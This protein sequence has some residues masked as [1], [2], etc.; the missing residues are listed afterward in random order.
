[1]FFQSLASLLLCLTVF[2]LEEGAPSITPL[3]QFDPRNNGDV[4]QEKKKKKEEKKP[5]MTAVH[6][7]ILKFFKNLN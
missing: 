5:L 2:V 7:F 4:D 6:L 3:R 1:M